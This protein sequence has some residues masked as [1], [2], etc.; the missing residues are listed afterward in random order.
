VRIESLTV[1]GFRCFGPQPITVQLSS[2]ITAVV[3][4]NAAGKTALLHA[5][6]KL[7]GVTR[8]QRNVQ[9]SDFHLGAT[10]DPDNR[11]PKSLFIEVMISLPELADGTATPETIA[12]SFRHM[13][14]AR[15]GYDPVCRVHLEARWEDDGTVEGE[16]SQEIFW[17]DSLDVD[18]GE[19]KRHAMSAADRGLIQLYYTPAS[20]DAAAQVKATSGALAA[21]LLR[22]IE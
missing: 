18:P 7:F 4:P 8:A 9:R 10:D 5:M 3:G 1:S 17:I 21:R 22:A 14:I 13:Q 12:P 6:S 16:V 11:N 19:D 15:S 2:E 20:R